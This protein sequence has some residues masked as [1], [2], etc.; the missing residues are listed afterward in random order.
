MDNQ[1]VFQDT[2]SSRFLGGFFPSF[3][4]SSYI[5]CFAET[6]NLGPVKITHICFEFH[7]HGELNRLLSLR[8]VNEQ[9]LET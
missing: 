8:H 7:V 6:D 5:K 2:N 9:H 3:F 1:L 4:L